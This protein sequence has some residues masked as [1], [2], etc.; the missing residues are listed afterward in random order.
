MRNVL[1]LSATLLSVGHQF[2]VVQVESWSWCWIASL[3]VHSCPFHATVSVLSPYHRLQLD[4]L[5]IAVFSVRYYLFTVCSL[6]RCFFF[7]IFW[8]FFFT[9]ALSFCSCYLYGRRFWHQ[10][11]TRCVWIFRDTLRKSISFQAWDVTPGASFNFRGSFFSWVSFCV[12]Y[13]LLV[14]N[15]LT[16]LAVYIVSQNILMHCALTGSCVDVTLESFKSVPV[17]SLPFVV[18]Q[19]VQSKR[20]ET[21]R[22]KFLLYICCWSLKLF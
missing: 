7:W 5:M 11:F 15:W 9:I 21:G 4:T 10:L 2:L 3:R 6:H 18:I 22:W 19:Y 17:G 16:S 13:C 20:T 1:F 8:A 12:G 14:C